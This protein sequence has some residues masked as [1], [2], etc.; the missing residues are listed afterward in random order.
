LFD[1]TGHRFARTYIAAEV[2]IGHLND[3]IRVLIANT[4]RTSDA[5]ICVD[6]CPCLASSIRIAGLDAVAEQAIIAYHGLDTR[7][8]P[9][10]TGTDRGALITIVTGKRVIGESTSSH[11]ITGIVRADIAIIARQL[12]EACGTLTTGTCISHR[13]C[14]PV[15][16]DTLD[17]GLLAAFKRIAT[18]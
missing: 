7:T 14:V 16:A 8:L 10:T 17:R 18:V 12:R 3:R 4:I 2:V 5:V 13:A 11:R 6:R 1:I 9:I 15:V